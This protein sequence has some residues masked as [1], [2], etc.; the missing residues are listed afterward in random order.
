[1]EPQST[2]S[3]PSTLFSASAAIS[4]VF[5]DSWLK[6]RWVATFGLGLAYGFAFSFALRPALQFAGSHV[7]ASV[8]SFDLG[9]GL[10]QLLVVALLVPALGLLFRYAVAERT[11]TIILAA[12]AAH[13]AWHWTMDRLGLLQKFRFEWP[14]VDAAFLAGAMRWMMLVVIAAGLYWLTF[15]VR[16]RVL[17]KR[18]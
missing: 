2:R 14:A 1:M 4:A 17:R 18:I 7:A 5:S 3:S 9:A 15:G 13:T 8:M 12:L 11:G 16:T 6:R 10:A